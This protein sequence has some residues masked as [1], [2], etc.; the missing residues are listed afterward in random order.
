M[1]SWGEG[2]A[3]GLWEGWASSLDAVAQG[4]GAA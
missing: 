2:S 3:F 1:L 4:V